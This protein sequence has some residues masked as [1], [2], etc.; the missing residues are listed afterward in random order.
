[1][2][3]EE[4]DKKTIQSRK[5]SQDNNRF[6]SR[7]AIRYYQKN[8]RKKKSGRNIV[9][10]FI[11]LISLIITV[12]VILNV[13]KYVAYKEREKE[14]AGFSDEQMKKDIY[15][16]YSLIG[17]DKPLSIRGKTRQEI[18]DI[19]LNSYKWNL[20]IKN[21][22]PEID[23][24][25]MPILDKDDTPNYEEIV[26]DKT[27]DNK[28]TSQEIEIEDVYKDITIRPTKNIYNFPD[29]IESQLKAQIDEIYD[30]YLHDT[31]IQFNKKNIDINSP[32][33]EADFTF[34][35]AEN[36]PEIDNLLNQ[37][38][39]LW[40]TKAVKGQIDGF[41]KQKNEFTFG[42]DHKGYEIDIEA[43]RIKIMQEVK[44][45]NFD[46]EINTIL[47]IIDPI[48]ESIKTKYRYISEYETSTT[49]NEIR[50][51]NI[52]L[53]CKAINGRIIKPNEEFSFNTIVGERTEQKGYGYATA[54]NNG[55]VVE[56]L[57]GGVCQVSTTLYNATFMAGL[58]TTYR[59][60]HTFEPNY[61]TP[62]LD[63]T[64]SY[65]GVDYRFINDSDY[66][67]GIRANFEKGR[68]KVE[69]FSV[70]ILEDGAKQYLESKKIEEFDEPPISIIESGEAQRGTKGSE[71]QVFKVIEKKD[72]SIEKI[73][74]HYAR[75]QG[76]TPTAYES[77]T[78]KDK[79]GVLHTRAFRTGGTT[80]NQS[81]ANRQSNQQSRQQTTRATTTAAEVI[82]QDNNSSIIVPDNVNTPM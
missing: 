38:A 37:L 5:I 24:F 26:N 13:V 23:L 17:M 46:A 60:S 27:V 64:V 6:R 32:N 1:M 10:F 40:N 69:I 39:K 52:D 8:S 56:E 71:W 48:G 12:F 11:V 72:G 61:I 53:A 21:S 41:D 34:S 77:N 49:D 59:R 25:T 18:Y 58:T 30:N 51:T 80:R 74:N 79:E 65:P 16:D 47:K 82:P 54:Y 76:H 36:D 55:E 15:I 43:L 67:I 66:S 22:N 68:I 81:Q 62:G 75:Y 78:Y 19:V 9:T 33:F 50:N 3:F 28:G 45:G 42:D 29:F 70:P 63:A 20:T 14:E 7:D 57:G 35:L 44:N 73:P 4:L 2:N 31:K